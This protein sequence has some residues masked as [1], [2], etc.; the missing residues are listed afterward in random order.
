[1]NGISTIAKNCTEHFV[2][3][4]MI[5]SAKIKGEIKM[6]MVAIW[7]RFD[8]GIWEKITTGWWRCLLEN[9]KPVEEIS[10]TLSDPVVPDGFYEEELQKPEF[11]IEDYI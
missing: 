7:K 8:D 11:N 2:Q 10:Q 6:E 3:F 5:K 4:A 9:P 1:M